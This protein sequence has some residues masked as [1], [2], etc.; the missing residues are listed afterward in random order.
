MYASARTIVR[1]SVRE[2]VCVCSW[3]GVCACVC[4][5]VCASVLRVDCVDVSVLVCAYIRHIFLSVDMYRDHVTCCIQSITITHQ[6]SIYF[7]LRIL[8]FEKLNQ[9]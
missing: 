2:L 8:I 1:V 3:V 6:K 7:F 4:A 9:D 5:C